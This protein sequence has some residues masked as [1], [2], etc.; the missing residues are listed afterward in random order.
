MLSR[1]D[2]GIQEHFL[3]MHKDFGEKLKVTSCD[4]VNT[5]VNLEKG[6]AEVGVKITWYRIDEMIVHSTV[7]MQY[8]EE[9]DR[10]WF[11]V[12]EEYRSGTPF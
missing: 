5:R 11:L 4:V 12:R 9:K 2:P 3:K 6:T 7:L 10:Q 1:V 8:W